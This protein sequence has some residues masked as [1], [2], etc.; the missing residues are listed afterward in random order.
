MIKHSITH[1]NATQ[2]QGQ[3]SSIEKIY[4]HP[5]YIGTAYY[6]IAV[7]KIA[8]VVFGPHLRPICLPDPSNFDIDKYNDK[9]TT[10]IGWGSK[11][12]TSNPS[13]TLKRVILTIYA[14]R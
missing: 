11:D 14:N 3:I 6:D 1:L 9:T 7:L 4:Q 13:S 10:L 8:S 12:T 2:N 5:K